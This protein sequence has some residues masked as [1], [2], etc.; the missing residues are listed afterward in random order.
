MVTV[1][2]GLFM[3]PG[4]LKEPD[5]LNSRICLPFRDLKVSLANWG[6]FVDMN[7]LVGQDWRLPGKFYL[8]TFSKFYRADNTKRM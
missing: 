2:S 3:S 7:A 6:G 1:V 5:T 4:V 8:R